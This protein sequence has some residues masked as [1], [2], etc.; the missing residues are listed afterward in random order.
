MAGVEGFEPT[1]AGIKTRCLNH[2]AT[3]QYCGGY[4][5]WPLPLS[6][7]GGHYSD[8]SFRRKEKVGF[9]CISLYRIDILY[10]ETRLII[11]L[12]Q[13]DAAVMRTLPVTQFNMPA[14][15]IKGFI[16]AFRR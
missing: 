13:P 5:A 7:R 4:S 2:L 16:S 3:P 14:F 11:L 9:L 1:N 6:A 10:N 8:L 12:P 15:S